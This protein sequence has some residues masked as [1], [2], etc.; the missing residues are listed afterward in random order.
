MKKT[1]LLNERMDKTNKNNWLQ[2]TGAILILI[3]ATSIFPE[4]DTWLHT[5]LQITF[6][7]GCVVF[8]VGGRFSKKMKNSSLSLVFL[9]SISFSND[10]SV[11]NYG[12]LVKASKESFNKKDI[13]II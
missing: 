3:G 10:L 1:Q 6:V 2:V 8:I 7:L 13:T 9:L 4:N 5:A 12:K 11:Q